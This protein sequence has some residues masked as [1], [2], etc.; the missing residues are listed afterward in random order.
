MKLL[1]VIL[2]STLVF[3][4]SCKKDNNSPS[5][6][7]NGKTA[8]V[9][10][11]NL[12]YGNLSDA[13]ANVYKTIKI[14]TQTWMAENLRTFKYNDGISIPNVADNTAW[15]NLTSGAYCTYNNTSKNDSIATYGCLYN[16]YAVSTGKLAP[17]GW[18]VATDDDWTTLI[19]YLITNGY[20]YDGT[21]SGYKI[22]KA[23]AS[24]NGWTSSTDA[25]TPGNTDFPEYRNKTGFTALPGGY[26]LG[27]GT[28]YSIDDNLNFWSATGYSNTSAYMRYMENTS[29]TLT[30]ATATFKNGYS[31]RCIKN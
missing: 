28:F 13:D 27:S 21:A 12:T 25:G 4:I 7:T 31:V 10:N 2:A 29:L 14:G 1:T 19:N 9:F 30:S 5:N 22:A 6:P 15:A 26:R 24:T 3:F 18:H 20:N 8:A 11:S 23:M 17:K 16:W